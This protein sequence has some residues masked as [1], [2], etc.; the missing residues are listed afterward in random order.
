MTRAHLPA[1][2]KQELLETYRRLYKQ[3]DVDEEEFR[4]FLAEIG[5]NATAIEEEINST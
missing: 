3:K 2:E 1:S 5:F 4:K